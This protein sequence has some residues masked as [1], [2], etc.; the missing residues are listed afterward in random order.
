MT[1]GEKLL[2][3]E[4]KRSVTGSFSRESKHDKAGD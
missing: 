1:F 3:C 4:K 2:S